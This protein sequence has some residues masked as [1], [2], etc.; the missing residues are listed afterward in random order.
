ML[1]QGTFY[2]YIAFDVELKQ[3]SNGKEYLSN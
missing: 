1:N 2:G 3:S